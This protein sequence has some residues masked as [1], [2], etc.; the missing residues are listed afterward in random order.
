MSLDKF[1]HKHFISCRC[2]L[3]QHMKYASPPQFNFVVFSKFDESGNVIPKFVQCP[4]CGIVHKVI[5]I[6]SSTIIQGK[7]ASNS[8][9]TI[10]DIRSMIPEKLQGLLDSSGCDI[11]VW[12]AIECIIENSLWGESVVISVEKIDGL[13]TVKSVKVI[14][15]TLYKVE[16]NVINDVITHL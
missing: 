1:G 16:S 6:C 7:E 3:N 12:E 14:G 15:S 11:S 2:I 13:K 4:N 9:R 8:I 5:D 10:D